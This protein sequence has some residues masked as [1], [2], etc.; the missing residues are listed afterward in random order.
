[1]G[2]PSPEDIVQ[3]LTEWRDGKPGA[4]DELWP[5]VQGE[6]HRLAKSYMRQERSGH[7]LQTTGLV[8]EVYQPGSVLRPRRERH[9]LFAGRLRSRS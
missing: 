5:V 2:A 4:L 3:L 1:M 9:A 7:T 8:G 6:L